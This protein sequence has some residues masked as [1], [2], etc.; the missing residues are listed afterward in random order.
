MYAQNILEGFLDAAKAASLKKVPRPA[1][2]L[3]SRSTALKKHR[4]SGVDQLMPYAES[5]KKCRS[6]IKARAP[7]G[8]RQCDPK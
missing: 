6:L 7:L 5:T 4:V 1:A 2:V 8:A 3:F